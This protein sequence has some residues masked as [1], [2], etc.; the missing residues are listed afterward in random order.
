VQT[1]N[2]HFTNIINYLDRDGIEDRLNLAEIEDN[3]EMPAKVTL[4]MVRQKAWLL[5]D[6]F[7]RPI[8]LLVD[9]EPTFPRPP[10]GAR[11]RF[12]HWTSESDSCE[13]REPLFR[14]EFLLR[15]QRQL[16]HS[17]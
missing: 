4:K 16:D 3:F 9:R 7:G 2:L 5:M 14:F 8:P 12:A 10:N 1:T 11:R 15:I 17:L 13:K 6:V